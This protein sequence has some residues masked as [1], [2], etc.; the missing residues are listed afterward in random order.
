MTA[1]SRTPTADGEQASAT[2]TRLLDVAEQLFAERGIDATS[3]RAI[4][5]TAG[6]NLASVNYHFGS[7]DALFREVVARRLG[8]IN[9]ERLRLLEEAK[10]QA[11]DGNPPLE[12]VLSAFLAPALHLQSQ[13]PQEGKNI[14]NLMGR[15]YSDPRADELK[16]LFYGEFKE[17]FQRFT[18]ALKH[19]APDVADD[20][21]IWR[22]FFVVGAMAHLMSAGDVLNHASNGLCD[23]EDVEANIGRLVAFSAAGFR[24]PNSPTS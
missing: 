14:M 6:A 3:L 18:S 7:K 8:P 22:F 23:L 21:I 4:T 9:A 24:A 12:S 2:R 15:L 20:E 16:K 17:V 13:R 11:A 5:A 1:F 10:C 19:A